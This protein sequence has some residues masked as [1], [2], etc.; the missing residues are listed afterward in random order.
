MFDLM[1]DERLI[2]AGWMVV[3]GDNDAGPSRLIESQVAASLLSFLLDDSK[4][5]KGSE[6]EEDDN[7]EVDVTE[8]EDAI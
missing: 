3:V 4:E 6:G 1:V 8:D 2:E 7:K 5:K